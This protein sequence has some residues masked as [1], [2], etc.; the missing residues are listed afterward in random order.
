MPNKALLAE[1][2]N[3][4]QPSLTIH[5]SAY[6][7]AHAHYSI[8]ISDTRWPAPSR[9]VQDQEWLWKDLETFDESYGF[10]NESFHSVSAGLKLRPV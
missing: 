6:I 4:M 8:N 5:L 10:P 3:N 7:S 9:T 1:S 2:A